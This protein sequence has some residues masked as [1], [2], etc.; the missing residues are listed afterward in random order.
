MALTRTTLSAACAVG[1]SSLTVASA[2][3]LAAGMIILVDSEEM[4][5][6][7]AYVAASTTVPVIRAQSGTAQVAHPTT[8]GVV[9]GVASDFAAPG[10]QSAAQFA[11][12]GRPR[13]FT[14]YSATGTMA[15]PAPGTD[16]LVELNG[17]SVITL[18][19]PVPTKELDGS[20]LTIVGNGAAAHVLTFTGGLSGAGS[21]YDVITV[22]ATAP[23]AVQAIACNSVWVA[24]AAIPVAGTVTNVTGTLA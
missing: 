6:T 4:K 1:D 11:L 19:I 7:R 17:T 14:S 18:T 12:M 9:F 3:G 23:I 2:T 22:N 16:L 21:S 5:V 20:I 24:L 8:A 10:I 15:L 13:Y